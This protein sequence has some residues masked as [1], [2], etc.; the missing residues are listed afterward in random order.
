METGTA[1]SGPFSMPNSIEWNSYQHSTLFRGP[2]T[3][4]KRKKYPKTSPLPL[5]TFDNI[6]NSEAA[7][8]LVTLSGEY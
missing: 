3:T 7:K 8:L 6:T 5:V 1:T 2:T 4:V